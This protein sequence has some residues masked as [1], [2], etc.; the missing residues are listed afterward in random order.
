MRVIQPSKR[1]E[2]WYRE[3]LELLVKQLK[4]EAL[5]AFRVNN[6]SMS[7]AQRKLSLASERM[8]N[9]PV[10]GFAKR[11]SEMFVRRINKTQYQR[12]SDEYKTRFGID[13]APTVDEDLLQ[14]MIEA[15]VN[16]IT[17]IKTDFISQVG[18]EV[19]KQLFEGERSTG[20]IQIIH[21]R[22][23]VTMNRAKFI[24]RDQTA[25]LNSAI[26]R[27]RNNKLG[28]KTYIWTG[29]MD[30]RQRKDHK[31]MNGKLCRFDDATVY[32]DDNGETWKKRRS[33]GG[34]ELHPG[35]DYNCRCGMAPRLDWD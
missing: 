4:D 21:D 29:A 9:I 34:V 8:M 26:T 27:E 6:D 15:N 33:I 16:L 1:T 14:E 23:N 7:D 28:I 25:K 11:V 5:S 10:F 12:M 19:R 17:S 22:G 2:V 30:V 32:S 18:D 3:Q 35:E 31:V 24:A 20:L 13:I